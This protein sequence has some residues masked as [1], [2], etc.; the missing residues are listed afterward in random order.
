[1]IIPFGVDVIAAL[2]KGGA[3]W[4]K[5]RALVRQM[6]TTS[7]EPFTMAAVCS[8]RSM[9][10]LL[11]ERHRL[12]AGVEVDRGLEDVTWLVS[13]ALK[14]EHED[15]G[16][17][18]EGLYVSND[19][20][21]VR[22]AYKVAHIS[23]TDIDDDGAPEYRR[24]AYSFP[25]VINLM[26]YSHGKGIVRTN[27]NKLYFMGRELWYDGTVCACTRQYDS[28]EIPF[29]D[30]AGIREIVCGR[31]YTLLLMH[32][33]RVYSRGLA[34][35]PDGRIGMDEPFVRLTFPD[36]AC[37]SKIVSNGTK[38][39]YITLEGQC[40]YTDTEDKP[41]PG[42]ALNKCLTPSLLQSLTGRFVT[43]AFIT[44]QEIVIQDDSNR[45]CLL[46]MQPRPNMPRYWPGSA[47]VIDPGYIDGTVQPDDLPYF[48]DK[49]IDNVI[50]A[51][52][53]VYLTGADGRVYQSTRTKATDW[54]SKEIEFF[55]W[56]P[57]AVMTESRTTMIPSALSVLN[58]DV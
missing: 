46:R 22:T 50:Q 14:I 6:D 4:W 18:V 43:N 32:G 15:V 55:K 19:N 56:N 27:D 52:R 57:V 20:F 16:K 45:L 3:C 10:L 23:I 7:I 42:L 26:G 37:I 34:Y 17:A 41:H 5:D 54:S 25:S 31:V 48:D 58:H 24:E 38:I 47:V 11:T 13:W 2:E 8:Q 21:A 28:T 40:Y 51:S 9:I 33:G 30:V 53:S 12:Q 36:N 44:K 49:D 1:M 39:I 29:D 35:R